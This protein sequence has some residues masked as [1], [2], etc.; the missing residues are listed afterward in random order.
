MSMAEPKKKIDATWMMALN[1]LVPGLGHWMIGEKVRGVIFFVTITLTYWIGVL[2]GGAYSTVNFRANTA[3]FFGEMFAGG[4]T[5]LAMLIGNL[6]GAEASYSKTLDLAT[7]YTG[8]A[9]LLNIFVILDILVRLDE[10]PE[11]GK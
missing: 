11:A 5:L 2:I 4:Y 7:I 1:W 9:G 8:V 3:W 6:P 10:S